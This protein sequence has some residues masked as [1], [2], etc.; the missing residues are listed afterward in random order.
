MSNLGFIGLGTMGGQMVARLLA[1]GHTVIGYNRTREKAE[2]LIA[3]GMRW[4]S[5]PR[6]V[7]SA[8]DITFA[9]VTNSAA[10]TSIA[11]GLD[12]LVAGLTEG[13]VFV[14]ISTVAPAVSRALAARVR[15][16]GADMMD[17][18]VS[19]SVITLQQGKLSVMVGGRA[20]T[21]ERLKP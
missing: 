6:E 9:M 4:A 18:P 2:R 20:E 15:E 14:D 12:G 19:G 16:K 17:A 3:K 10:L 13:K 5:S 1:K 21:F 8:A 11:D 7:A